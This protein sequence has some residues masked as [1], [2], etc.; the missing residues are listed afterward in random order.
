MR[1]HAGACTCA[2]PTARELVP[3]VASAFLY[4]HVLSAVAM[5]VVHLIT[6]DAFSG[7]VETPSDRWTCSGELPVGA[8]HA[9]A[10]HWSVGGVVVVASSV[11]TEI[12]VAMNCPPEMLSRAV[13]DRAAQ[14]DRGG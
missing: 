5:D 14:I 2:T 12:F 9:V 4:K 7:F 8:T 6:I 13:F 10:R 1:S 11:D 3:D